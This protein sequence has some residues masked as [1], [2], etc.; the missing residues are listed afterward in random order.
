MNID[1]VRTLERRAKPRVKINC[2]LIL[3]GSSTDG[4]QFEDEGLLVDISACG[5]FFWTKKLLSRGERL[6]L[7]IQL[8]GEDPVRGIKSNYLRTLGKVVRVDCSSTNSYGVA[9]AIDQYQFF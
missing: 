6:N 1:V 9:I 3:Q 2:P 7:T 8:S 5:L 4:D